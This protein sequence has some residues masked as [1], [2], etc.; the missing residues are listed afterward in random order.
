M[1]TRDF[2]SNVDEM[3]VNA[4]LAAAADPQQASTLETTSQAT[5]E[6][7]TLPLQAEELELSGRLTKADDHRLTSPTFSS[8]VNVK[9]EPIGDMGLNAKD[10]ESTEKGAVASATTNE[11]QSEE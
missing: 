1:V 10:T 5:G 7:N 4:V 9:T 11:N 2:E 3:V 8:N 6:T